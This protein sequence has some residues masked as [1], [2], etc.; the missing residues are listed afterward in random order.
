MKVLVVGGGGREHALC[1]TVRRDAPDADLFAAPGN[2]GT[3]ALATNLPIAVTAT[4]DLVRAAAEQHIDLVIVGPEGPLAAGLA[5][6]LRAA[7]IATFGPSAAAAQL[8]ASKAFA[9]DIMRRAGVATAA[10]ATFTELERATAFITSHAEPLVVKAS[11]LAG[12]KGAVVCATRADA[13]A[14]ARAML[15]DGRF[16]DAGREIVIE[17]FL[18]GE[19]LSVLALTDGEQV[20]ILPPAQDH[21]R[22]GEGDSGPNTGGM[23]A[24]APVSLATR[25]LLGR[26]RRE[27]LV[28]T[29]RAM[30]RAGT[31]YKGVL[32]AGL[33]IRPDGS[34][35]VIE[36]NC[37]FGDPETQAVMPVL[38]TGVT[39]ALGAIA[40]GT[41]RPEGEVIDPVGA[42]VTIVLASRGYP[43]E[44]ATG[45]PITIPAGLS[46]D[47]TVFHAGTSQDPDGTLRV[48]GG[49]VLNVT[50]IGPDVATAAERSLDACER[51]RFDGKTYRRDIGRR[52]VQ[53]ARAP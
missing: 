51:I 20:V 33:M 8:E 36:F 3:A 47:V 52:E 38:P 16:G 15:T 31:P 12:G 19:E 40:T 24:Y 35:A 39:H 32:Y 46:A 10:S 30:T 13:H 6:Q 48:K 50:A 2:P 37:R 27:V 42:A 18:D 21:K 14:A 23:G 26:V 11:G 25:A 17:D 34:P 9:K 5:D 44:P 43:D 49:R 28:P 41:W 29:L 22:L 53:R 7:G 45:A 4:D 1:W